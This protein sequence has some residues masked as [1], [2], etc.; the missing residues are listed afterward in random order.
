METY[1]KA[2]ELLLSAQGDAADEDHDGPDEDLIQ[3]GGATNGG[4]IHGSNESLKATLL[5]MNET[6]EETLTAKPPQPSCVT[7][8]SESD[9]EGPGAD[10]LISHEE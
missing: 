8:H 2:R 1:R 6:K 10:F 3:Y 5:A 9:D 4:V 7:C